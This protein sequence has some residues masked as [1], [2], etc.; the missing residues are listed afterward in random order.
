MNKKNTKKKPKVFTLGGATFDLFVQAEDQ[1]IIT[2]QTPA[3]SQ[4]WLAFP[5]GAKVPIREV[6]ETFGGGGTN[7]AIAF[8]GM[9]FDVTYVGKVGHQYSDRVFSN[10][11]AHGVDTQYIKRTTLDKTGFSNIINTF[12]GDRTLL[13]YSGA[14][15]FFSVKDLPIKALEKADWIFLNHLSEKNSQIPFKLLSILK[16]NPHIKLAWNPGR[17]QIQRGTEYWKELLW[18]TEILF[19]NKEEAAAFSQIPFQL[20]GIKKD[21]PRQHVNS[22]SFLPPYADDAS[23]ILQH[24]IKKGVKIVAITDGRNG[25]QAADHKQNKYFC[26]ILS[27]KRVDTLGAGDAFGSGFT[28]ALIEGLPL[29]TALIYATLNAASVVNAPGAQNGLLTVAKM[30]EALKKSKIEVKQTKL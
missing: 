7:T 27:H 18:H 19:L 15:R 2:L 28:S 6:I 1:S 16:K 25:A 21:D 12:D 29:K 23:R 10:L 13:N 26:P 3:S 20:A 22:K 9:G 30:K 14:N 11:K 4:K 24:F 17:E 8:A 5:H